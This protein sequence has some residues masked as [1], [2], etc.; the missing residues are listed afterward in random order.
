MP[1]TKVPEIVTT[2]FPE[3]DL[4]H[5][6]YNAF[7]LQTRSHHHGIL[8]NISAEVSA[9]NRVMGVLIVDAQAYFDGLADFVGNTVVLN[10]GVSFSGVLFQRRIRDLEYFKRKYPSS[11]EFVRRGLLT[12]RTSNE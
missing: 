9:R 1:R 11:R 2:Y 4:L 10:E 7:G 5:I 3:S 12:Q 6:N 8:P